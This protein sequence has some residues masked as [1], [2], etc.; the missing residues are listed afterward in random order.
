V[1]HSDYSVSY[2]LIIKTAAKDKA[3]TTETNNKKTKLIQ[4]TA[5][6]RFNARYYGISEHLFP[7][8]EFSSCPANVNWCTCSAKVIKI[9]QA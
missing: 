5:N 2:S 1:N 4:I 8:H 3:T 6:N 7:L 9:L